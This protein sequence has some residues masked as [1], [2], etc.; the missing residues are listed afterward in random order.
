MGAHGSWP[1]RRPRPR[2]LR[3]PPAWAGGPGARSPPPG[4][5]ARP[6]GGS[7]AQR[8]YAAPRRLGAGRR[9]PAAL[10]GGVASRW[11][12][13]RRGQRACGPGLAWPASRPY[14]TPTRP[15]CAGTRELDVASA[16][17]RRG[18][19]AR[20][21]GV[22]CLCGGPARPARPRHGSRC[23][24]ATSAA[25]AARHSHSRHCAQ[26][27]FVVRWIVATRDTI[28]LSHERVRIQ[29]VHIADTS[30]PVLIVITL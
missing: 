12:S 3:R 28:I 14:S 4:V 21:P 10:R 22:A 23:P 19:P 25:R 7:A 30:D 16:V 1:G 6:P 17:A 9:G 5:D 27:W 24:R 20:R 26:D 8:G 29:C 15:T 13:A 2:R 11:L 18:Q